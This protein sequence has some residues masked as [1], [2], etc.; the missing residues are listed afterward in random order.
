MASA[1]RSSNRNLSS[2]DDLHRRLEME[3]TRRKE[4]ESYLRRLCTPQ[5]WAKHW[6]ETTEPWREITKLLE[7]NQTDAN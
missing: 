6:A 5:R 7:K 4:L 1:F 2:T 3:R